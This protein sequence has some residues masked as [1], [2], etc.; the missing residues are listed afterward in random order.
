MKDCKWTK[1]YYLI[2]LTGAMGSGKSEAAQLFQEAG[3]MVVKADELAHEVLQSPVLRPALLRLL[4]DDIL[5]EGRISRPAVAAKVFGNSEKLEKLNGLIHPEV[6]RRFT[7]I[8]SGLSDG[9]ILVYEVPLLFEAGLAD[10]FDLTVTVSAPEDVRYARVKA[11]NNWSREE[12]LARDRA[13]LPLTEKEK[14]AD[15]VIEN[16]GSKEDLEAAV[17]DLLEKVRRARK[18]QDQDTIP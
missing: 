15:L 14:L 10:Q 2:G 3:A 18:R 4:G 13:Q 17:V 7:E 16:T 1:D 9:Q 5:A 11:R 8:Q 12:F 6:R